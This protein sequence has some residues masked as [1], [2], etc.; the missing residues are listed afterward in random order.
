VLIGWG[1]S[2]HVYA[3][4]Y[5]LGEL[6][7]FAAM[8]PLVWSALY[9]H[10]MR[11]TAIGASLVIGSFLV[12]L[13]LSAAPVTRAAIINAVDGGLLVA[14]GVPCGMGAAYLEGTS[15]ILALSLMCFWLALA[16]FRLGFPLHFDSWVW[17]RLNEFL[18]TLIVAAGCLWLARIDRRCPA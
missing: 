8:I 3:W 18:P 7:V 11:S 1:E 5:I 15:R 2:S 6:I 10:P 4:A 14:F 9:F 16:G 12:W 13:S 17:D